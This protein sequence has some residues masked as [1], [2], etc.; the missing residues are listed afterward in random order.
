MF[1]LRLLPKAWVCL[2][3][4]LRITVVNIGQTEMPC[5]QQNFDGIKINE[6]CN[7]SF[8]RWGL[9]NQKAGFPGQQG[10]DGRCQPRAPHHHP[11]KRRATRA[12]SGTLTAKGDLLSWPA[13]RCTAKHTPLP[14]PCLSS[15][16][17]IPRGGVPG[18]FHRSGLIIHLRIHPGELLSW[19][20]GCLVESF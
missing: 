15:R 20:A 13:F 5:C 12:W 10:W 14:E 18:Q 3:N 4:D 11:A 2:P 19:F 8:W 1:V 6:S 17:Q 9:R 7:F 16:S